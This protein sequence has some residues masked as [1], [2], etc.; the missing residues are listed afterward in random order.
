MGVAREHM[1]CLDVV[2]IN[3]P[4]QNFSLGIV[5]IALLDKAMAF[6][7]DELLEL[8][9]VPMLSFSDAWLADIDADL[10]TV[11][12]MNQFGERAACIDIHLQR[13]CG[14]L[15]GQIAQVGA[16]EFLGESSMS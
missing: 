14:L 12:G 9:V 7:D 1:D 15:I 10:A 4:F 8:R 13:E 6:H 5:Q 2:A 11:E 16:V 3:F